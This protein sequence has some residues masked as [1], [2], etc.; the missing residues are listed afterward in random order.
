MGGLPPP[1]ASRSELYKFKNYILFR[2]IIR[3]HEKLLTKGSKSRAGEKAD[4]KRFTLRNDRRGASPL[5]NV[6]KMLE[7][8][9]FFACE[10]DVLNVLKSELVPRFFIAQ[11]EDSFR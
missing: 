7:D 5:P 4:P 1:L 3:P 9:E 10:Y 2:T 6:K 8:T 11:G